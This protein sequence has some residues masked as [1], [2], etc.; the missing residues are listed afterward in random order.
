[1]CKGSGYTR[2]TTDVRKEGDMTTVT[3]QARQLQEQ[4]AAAIHPLFALIDAQ[5]RQRVWVARQLGISRQRLH[6]YELGLNRPP[7]WVLDRMCSILGCPRT[8]LPPGI[9]QSSGRTY[10]EGARRGGKASA[11]RGPPAA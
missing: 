1:M 11:A 3:H 8:L 6:A 7:E 9:A 5:G 10:A 4:R 2:C